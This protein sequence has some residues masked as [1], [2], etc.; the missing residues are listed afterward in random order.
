MG[1]RERQDV[2][3]SEGQSRAADYAFVL[4]SGYT[5]IE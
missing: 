3:L 1:L 4:Q 5:E 2:L